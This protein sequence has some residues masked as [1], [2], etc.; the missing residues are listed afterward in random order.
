M[1][2]SLTVRHRRT[3]IKSPPPPLPPMLWRLMKRTMSA[4]KIVRDH[5]FIPYFYLF[6][7]CNILG[8]GDCFLNIFIKRWTELHLIHIIHVKI[9]KGSEGSDTWSLRMIFYPST[10]SFYGPARASPLIWEAYA[11]LRDECLNWV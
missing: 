10:Y 6:C 4:K 8:G 7:Y 3:N 9:S 11:F 1:S 2:K 5:V